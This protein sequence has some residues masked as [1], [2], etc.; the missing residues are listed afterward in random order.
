MIDFFGQAW[1]LLVRM[2]ADIGDMWQTAIICLVLSMMVTQWLKPELA[3]LREQRRRRTLQLTA[4]VTAS[5]PLALL[6]PNEYG[7]LVAVLTGVASPT[8]Y[9]VTTFVIA[10]RWPSLAVALSSDNPFYSVTDFAKG[11]EPQ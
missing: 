11:K 5:V 9:Q 4:F 10:K 8:L 1:T 2:A 3:G 6:Q 7:V